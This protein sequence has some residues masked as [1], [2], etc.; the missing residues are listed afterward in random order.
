MLV[1]SGALRKASKK[2]SAHAQDLGHLL[3]RYGHGTCRSNHLLHSLPSSSLA[4]E[5]SLW[6]LAMHSEL[7][8]L[9]STNDGQLLLSYKASG[10]P[11]APT[12]HSAVEALPG[13]V[14]QA[15]RKDH[16]R[17]TLSIT[18][19]PGKAKKTP[20]RARKKKKK[21][22]SF[23]WKRCT[24]TPNQLSRWWTRSSRGN[25]FSVVKKY[26]GRRQHR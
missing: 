11:R 1:P 7:T 5:Q 21:K 22:A 19:L 26:N 25:E 20:L 12:V 13:G 24:T 18:V 10:P 2:K 3:L 17:K 16:T 9:L 15:R 8:S 14:S 6:R 4:A 23:Y